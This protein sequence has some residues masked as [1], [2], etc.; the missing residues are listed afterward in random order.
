M[1]KKFIYFAESLRRN[2]QVDVE[3]DSDDNAL[4]R[5]ISRKTGTDEEKVR[6]LFRKLRPVIRGQ[7]EV[8]ETLMKDLID[9]MNEIEKPQP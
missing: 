1:R 2:I 7:Q 8:G 6:N 3:D 9:G 5:R 4:S